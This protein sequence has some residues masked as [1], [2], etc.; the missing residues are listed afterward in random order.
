MNLI[1]YLYFGFFMVAN[2]EAIECPPPF[3]PGKK[4]PTN[5]S[6]PFDPQNRPP[7][8]L[9]SWFTEAVFNDLF[10]KSNLGWGV[11]KCRPYNYKA[12]IIATRYFPTFANEYVDHDPLGNKLPTNYTRNETYRRDLSAF[13]AHV[14]EETGE[15]D[16]DLYQ[17]LPREEADNCFY[18]GGFYNWFEGGP[19]SSFVKNNGLDPKDGE[20]CTQSG[21]YCDI[22]TNSHWFYPCKNETKSEWT[23]EC[24]FGRGA[25][26]ISYN[27]NYG[28]FSK[29]LLD[30][31]IMHN[32]APINLLENPN[33]L[34]TKI[35]PPLSI[36]ASLWFYM[37]PQPPKPAMHDIII[38]DWVSPDHDYFGSVFGPTSLV[39]NFDCSGEDPDVPGGGGENRR[40]KAFRWFTKYFNTPFNTGLPKTMSCKGF[41]N[42]NQFEFPYSLG[43]KKSWDVDWS[44]SWKDT[45]PCECVMQTY[46]APIF[47]FDPV[48]MPKY[49][50]YNPS[51]KKWCENNYQQGFGDQACAHYHPPKFDIVV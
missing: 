44:T 9:E 39:I 18:R 23:K 34:M 30:Q 28:L 51:N 21:E 12:F 2:Y 50:K 41:N 27:F 11:S 5:C 29:W 1:F 8:P 7:T 31:G 19:I 40:I 17:R 13:F 24:Y 35:D 42:N 3:K 20:F 25:I 36:M 48:I 32:G 15:N 22:S 26:Q 47:A 4:P 43:Y 14:I 37:T 33:L 45:V 46:S 10:P 6:E 49:Q 16:I 38:G